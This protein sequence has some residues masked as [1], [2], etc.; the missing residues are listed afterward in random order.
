[1]KKISLSLF[2][3]TGSF[4][5]KVSVF[6]F[7]CVINVVLAQQWEGSSAKEDVSQNYKTDVK[8]P[9]QKV[10]FGKPAQNVQTKSVVAGYKMGQID[11]G[12]INIYMRD[13]EISQN[14]TGITSC[15]MSFHVYSTLSNTV[16]NISFRLKWPELETPLSFDNI[17]SGKT[18]SQN[19]AFAGKVCYT[20]DRTPNV[21]VNR[22][23]V[24][25]M[26]QQECA[27]HIE[28][29]K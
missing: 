24:K 19:H 3:K 17:G 16:S 27:N 12:R 4:L 21:I 13:F 25:G 8:R 5:I 11:E 15:S 18:V 28:W 2:F 22:C 9:I 10:T 1:M 29:V 14:L 20:L 7:L 6:A 26:S 23:R